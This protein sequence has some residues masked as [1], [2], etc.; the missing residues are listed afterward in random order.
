M[1]SAGIGDGGLQRERAGVIAQEGIMAVTCFF[2]FPA[3]ST[4]KEICVPLARL[5]SLS[6]SVQIAGP[7]F[8]SQREAAF[9]CLLYG[10]EKGAKSGCWLL[11][12][13]S[14][15]P[16]IAL[17]WWPNPEQR[18]FRGTLEIQGQE[19]KAMYHGLGLAQKYCHWFADQCQL[20]FYCHYRCV[21]DSTTFLCVKLM[22][23]CQN[24]KWDS[25]QH[26]TSFRNHIS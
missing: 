15:I 23:S 11:K 4:H 17:Y 26:D 6:T 1:T 13:Q 2:F 21:C 10:L 12:N 3:Q 7:H 18:I 16:S 19:N 20:K 8:N 25:A 24:W 9:V 5:Y 14:G 22:S